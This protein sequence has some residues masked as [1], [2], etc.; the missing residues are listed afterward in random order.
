MAEND[1]IVA[2]EG[3]GGTLSEIALAPSDIGAANAS[4]THTAADIDSGASA[5]GT[6]L[7]SNGSGGSGWNTVSY[8]DLDDVPS[9]FTPASHTHAAADVTSGTFDN[10]RINFAA[11]A[12][13]GSTT[14][15]AGTFTTLTA[16]VSGTALTVTDT[17]TSV[18]YDDPFVV[19]RSSAVLFKVRDD[20]LCNANGYTVGTNVSIGI[21]GVKLRADYPLNWSSTGY[22]YNSSDT[23]LR[24]DEQANTLAM[25]NSTNSQEFRLY[26]TRTSSTN[27]ERGF[28]KWDSNVF[29]IGTEKGS[30]GGTA[31]TIEFLTGGTKRLEFTSGGNTQLASGL[32]LVFATIGR[33]IPSGADG[34]LRITNI[35]DSGFNRLQFGGITSS[36]PSLKRNST[37]LEARLADDSDYTA[38]QGKLTT[39]TAYTAGAPTATGYLVLYDSNGT[40]YKVPAEAL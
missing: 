2:K 14:P 37:T 21:A 40:A 25:H 16:S 12:A 27:Y 28:L 31:R 23:F 6:F 38:I 39:E 8:E 13:I 36:F 17:N 9:S 30:G 32:S 3:S 22:T 10:A 35:G 29:K 1:I 20:G 26:N 18:N 15:A 33:I 24:R 19:Q 4:H 7:Q 11:P 34:V 5:S